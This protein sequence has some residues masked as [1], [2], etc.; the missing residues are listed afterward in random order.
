MRFRFKAFL[1]A[2]PTI[3]LIVFYMLFLL[4]PQWFPR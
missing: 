1:L 3:A 4:Y 2:V